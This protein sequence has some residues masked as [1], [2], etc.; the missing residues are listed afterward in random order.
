MTASSVVV[1]GGGL[2]GATAAAR[3]H[4]LQV[5]VVV[6]SDRP[7]ATSMHGG[8]WYL[9][10]KR[11]PR[12]GLPGPRI[13]EALQ[14]LGEGLDGELELEDGPFA[15][16]DTDGVR[17]VV[18]LA[19]RNHARAAR[20]KDYAV[21][22][23]AP[24]G[25]PFAAMHVGGSTIEVDYPNW[26]GAFDRSFAAVATRLEASE[27]EQEALSDA[28]VKALEGS[29]YAGLL[30]PPVLGLQSAGAI[31]A[32][33]EETLGIPVAEALG[34][35]PS[36]PGIRLNGALYR[37]LE[38][39]GVTLRRGRV[40][41]IDVG[42]SAVYLGEERIDATAIVL[43]TGGVIS[44]GLAVGA[45]PLAELRIEPQ[46]PIDLMNAVHPD[47]PYGG[48]LFRAGVPVDARQQPIRH[49]GAPVHPRLFAAGD[50]LAGPDN[51]GDRCSSG[52][53]ALSGY[54]AAEHVAEVL[55]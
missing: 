44:G 31:R 25:H 39:I 32:R 47:R 36:T 16:A 2:A 55:P 27:S 35:A 43:A 17:R 1:V 28:L 45:E 20:L 54:L 30:L 48:A 38:R 4:A 14:L 24:L 22:D 29:T 51:V 11:L 5:D 3:L 46:L 41:A 19:P 23:L 13:G 34:T 49:D 26:E 18:D 8:G 52:F 42:E 37:W 40:T 50:V 7:G 9:G 6:I 33:L 12:F 15:L 21:A 10:L 53:A